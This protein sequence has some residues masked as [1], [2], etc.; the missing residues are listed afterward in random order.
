LLLFSLSKVYLSLPWFMKHLR[1][2]ENK[3]SQFGDKIWPR[4]G[5]LIRFSYLLNVIWRL[6][7]YLSWV[8]LKWQLQFPYKEL[9]SVPHFVKE[10]PDWLLR[11]TFFISQRYHLAK[12]KYT[13]VDKDFLVGL[14]CVLIYAYSLWAFRWHSV[15]WVTHKGRW[16]GS[17]FLLNYLV[18]IKVSCVY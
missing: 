8:E 12:I 17:G 14:K 18:I 5:Y 1:F 15:H 7:S 10:A 9:C 6:G 4:N 3:W 11:N 2:K 16:W 13:W